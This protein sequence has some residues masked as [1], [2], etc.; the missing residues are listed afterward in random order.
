MTID[1]AKETADRAVEVADGF[2][3]VATRHH[4]GGSHMFGEV[5]NRCL[6]FRVVD[7]GAP[8]LL[9]ING[10][11]AS[12]IDEVKRI[13]RETGL[14][15]RYI[16]S[17]GGGHHVLLPAWVDAFTQAEVMVGPTRIPRTANGRKL[18]SMPRVTTFDPDAILPQLKGQVELLS[19]RGLFGAPD[20][21][22]PGEG[23]HDGF[24]MMMTMMVSMMFRMKDPVD[25]LWTFHVPTGTLIGGENLGW[26]YPADAHMALPKM[27]KGMIKPDRVYVFKDARKVGDASMVDACWRA[28]LKWPATTVL[29][30]HDPAGHGFQGDG[31]A[32][33][34]QAVRESGQLLS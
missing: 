3:I 17:A 4:P 18:L 2:W 8:V 23:G 6:V 25:E 14:D 31:R 19:F 26:M 33:I 28:I 5:N 32:A 9:V 11:A 10:V 1:L 30:Y 20:Y 15:V 22:S 24:R 34:E 21:H 7:H 12:A 29:T 13:E 27:L 16:L